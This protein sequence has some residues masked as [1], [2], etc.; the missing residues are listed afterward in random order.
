MYRV[1]GHRVLIGVRR[2]RA[3]FRSSHQSLHGRL[4]RRN[5]SELAQIRTGRI[6]RGSCQQLHRQIFDRHRA[7][8]GES[9]Q[10]FLVKTFGFERVSNGFA[11]S[12]Q[13]KR[14]RL[15]KYNHRALGSI[16][17]HFDCIALCRNAGLGFGQR[18]VVSHMFPI[19]V[20]NL[21]KI[22][23][24]RIRSRRKSAQRQHP[25][26]EDG[27]HRKQSN[28]KMFFHDV[29]P[30][31]NSGKAP[32]CIASNYEQNL[33][34]ALQIYNLIIRNFKKTVKSFG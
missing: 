29:S 5:R 25:D 12:V 10:I 2:I 17:Q 22:S 33:F 8:S 9:K 23:L 13:N 7:G 18:C 24:G 15:V 31:V 1:L 11:V 3:G 34:E 6:L 32:I 21:I 27:H 28:A 16:L 14:K 30:F 4:G 19:R 20:K 26:H